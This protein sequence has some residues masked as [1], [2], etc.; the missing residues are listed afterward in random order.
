MNENKFNYHTKAIVYKDFNY[1]L[2]DPI[3]RASVTMSKS[4]AAFGKDDNSCKC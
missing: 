1:Y 3:C 2:T 4:A